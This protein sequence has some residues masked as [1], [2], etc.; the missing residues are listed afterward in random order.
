MPDW[1]HS[2]PHRL[3]EGGAYMVT[4]ATY[5]KLPL[6]QS[7]AH[8]SFLCDT[9]ASLAARFGWRLHSWAVFPNHYHFI[10]DCAPPASPKL[11]KKMIQQLHSLTAREVNTGDGQLGRQVWFQYWDTHLTYPKS[12]YARLR[13]VHE[14]AV[15]HRLV[16]VASAYPWCSAGWFEREADPAFRKTIL[17]FP[18]DRVT[19]PDDFKVTR[20]DF[21]RA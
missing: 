19:V 7:R 18:C 6:F 5:K 12:Y 14:N 13:Y 4:A 11:L 15:H 3:G 17:S 10:A 1:P 16:R 2:P 8:L 9:L 20:E 21:K